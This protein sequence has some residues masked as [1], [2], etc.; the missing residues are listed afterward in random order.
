MWHTLI[1][2]IAVFAAYLLGR[3]E[4][5][6]SGGADALRYRRI[7]EQIEKYDGRDKHERKDRKTY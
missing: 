6:R 1:T 5:K 2:L 7:L 3:R 4:R